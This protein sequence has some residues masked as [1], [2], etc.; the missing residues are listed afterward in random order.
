MPTRTAAIEYRQPPEADRA[1]VVDLVRISFNPPPSRLR[2][3]EADLTLE[4]LL[5][6]YAG[7]EL[8]AIARSHEFDQWFGGRP[9]PMAGIAAVAAVPEA[10]GGRYATGTVERLLKMRREAGDAISTLY[11]SRAEVYRRLGYEYSGVR[12]RWRV[13]L[14]AL[15][16][17]GSLPV[18]RFTPADREAVDA[19]YRAFAARGAGLIESKE[20][21]WW[22]QRILRDWAEQTTRAVVV[23]NEAGEVEGYA[24]FQIEPSG[25]HAGFGYRLSCTHLVSLTREA[26]ESLFN[27]FRRFRGIGSELAW[28]GAPHEPLGLLLESGADTLEPIACLRFMTRILDVGKA[29]A[30]RGWPSVT[31]EAAL[32]VADPMIPENDGVFLIGASG[33]SV[34]ASRTGARGAQS[35]GSRA[36]TINALSALYTGYLSPADL[37]RLGELDPTHPEYEFLRALFAPAPAWMFDMF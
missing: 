6:A 37:V 25:G 24:A 19:C 23:R 9:V 1:R 34:R 5:G 31:G 15:R 18:R 10:R 2:S 4:G 7:G 33:G 28:Y 36:I 29:L 30:A 21:T 35:H 26:G 17:A 27:Y 8:V 14:T 20:A 12:T 13:P 22:S 32:E 3:L 16:S 11:P